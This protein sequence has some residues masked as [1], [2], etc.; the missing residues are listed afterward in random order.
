VTIQGSEPVHPQPM[1]RAQVA[2]AAAPVSV[3]AGTTEVSVTVS[4]EV[5]VET[6]R[7]PSR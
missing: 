7:A 1:F 6:V 3:E 2:N 4:G 5:I